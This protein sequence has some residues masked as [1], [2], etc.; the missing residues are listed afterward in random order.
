MPTRLEAQSPTRTMGVSR[1]RARRRTWGEQVN[2]P[3]SAEIGLYCGT[4][5]PE[6]AESVAD[7]LGI[8]LGGPFLRRFPD[9]E[10]HFQIEESIRGKDIFIL[11]STS[12]PVNEH[13][14]ELLIM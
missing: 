14:M 13:L 10:V 5:N 8:Q 1:P 12:P 7:H 6:L 3:N 9:S 11:Q 2:D 4:A